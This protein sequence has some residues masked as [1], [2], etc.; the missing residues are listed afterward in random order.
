MDNMLD[1]DYIIKL[2]CIQTNYDGF[3]TDRI[4]H[5]N[6]KFTMLN[7]LGVDLLKLHPPLML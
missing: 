3:N 6:T 1:C 4:T 5:T 2:L 7:R